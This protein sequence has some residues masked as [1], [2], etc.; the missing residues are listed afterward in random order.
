MA[1]NPLLP[2][3]SGLPANVDGSDSFCKSQ[4]PAETRS[5]HAATTGSKL[6]PHPSHQWPM[7]GLQGTLWAFVEGICAKE[8]KLKNTKFNVNRIVKALYSR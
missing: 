5:R 8:D 7:V 3:L 6:S 4:Q 1:R 2:Q